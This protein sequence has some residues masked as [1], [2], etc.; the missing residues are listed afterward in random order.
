MKRKLDKDSLNLNLKAVTV[1]TIATNSEVKKEE[2]DFKGTTNSNEVNKLMKDR[3]KVIGFLG[4][5][6]V[7]ST[8]ETTQNYF[9][10][11]E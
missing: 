10:N 7:R 8:M 3:L 4:N 1:V 6:I 11:S 5:K 9:H 2:D